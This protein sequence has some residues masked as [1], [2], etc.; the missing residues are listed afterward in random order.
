MSEIGD[1]IRQVFRESAVYKNPANNEVFVGRNLPSFVKDYLIA[2]HIDQNGKLRRDDLVRFLD[3]HI[4]LNPNAIRSRLMQGDVIT[5]LTRFEISTNIAKNKTQFQIPEMG[6]KMADT[7]IPQY[8][9]DQNPDDLID[10]EKWGI[11]KLVYIPP[12]DKEKGYIEMSKYKPFRPLERL[13]LNSFRECRKKFTTDEWIDVLISAMEYTPSAFSGKTQK[14]EFL[15]RLLPF[16]EP[17]LN[18]I[19]LAPKGT[20]KSYVFGNLSKFVW[21]I[22]GGKVSRA[23]LFYDKSRKTPGIMFHH[24]LVALDEIQSITFTDPMEMRSILKNYLEYGKTNIDNFEF[25]SECGLILL[26]NISLSEDGFPMSDNYVEE[27]PEAFKESALLDRFHGFIE[28]WLLPRITNDMAL[29]DWTLN[30]EFFSEVLHQLRTAT[31]YATIVNQ[32]IA[33]PEGADMRHLKAVKRIAS[34]YLKLLFPH[35]LK[36]EDMDIAE[37]YTY[38]LKPAVHRRDIIRRQCAN[39]DSESSFSKPMPI[40]ELK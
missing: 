27:L 5:L 30:V 39:I 25:M 21:L 14:L 40:F 24:D 35:V 34:A 12:Q 10:G 11:I 28:G 23:K 26:G 32:S 2:T 7:D 37:F 13:D 16:I 6:I 22:G 36:K 9:V 3:E 18:L 29:R 15:A 8:V 31:E 4:P 19:E 38:C 20:G 33:V 1:K 17:R